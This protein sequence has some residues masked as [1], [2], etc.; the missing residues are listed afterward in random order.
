MWLSHCVSGLIQSGTVISGGKLGRDL[1]PSL[2][3]LRFIFSPPTPAT[4]DGARATQDADERRHQAE[5]GSISCA[6]SRSK[7]TLPQPSPNVL[8]FAQIFV[9]QKAENFIK[10]R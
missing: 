9:L 6:W 2:L 7:K 10:K 8:S 1:K 3:E 4:T 5:E